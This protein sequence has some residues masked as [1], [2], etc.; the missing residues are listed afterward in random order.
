MSLIEKEQHAIETLQAFVPKE[1]Y[2]VAFS[3]GKDSVTIKK[4]CDL[5]KVKYDSHYNVTSIDPPELVQFIKKEYPDVLFEKPR[6]KDG[7][8]ITMM[9][10]IPKKKMPPTRLVR[11]CCE[12]LKEGGGAGR[13][14]ITGVR[15]AESLNR[16]NNQGLVTVYKVNKNMEIPKGSELSSKG[17]LILNNDND[18]TREF[19]ESCYKLKK[20]VINP[21]IDWSDEDV[22][23]F[24]HKYNVP[25]CSLYDQGYKRLGCIG[26]PMQGAK[27]QIS[28]FHHYPKYFNMYMRAFEKMIK[29]RNKA[30]LETKWET[31]EQVMEWWV[32]V[33]PNDFDEFLNMKLKGGI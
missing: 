32:G 23:E 28:E 30:N 20:T 21:I 17:G 10:L 7:T 4:L 14:V 2:Y 12:K 1:G 29:E 11:Y 27:K 5:A 16:R 25:Y 13:M 18:D 19:L 3:G 24:I 26:C 31:P 33:N 9:N 6:Y 15:W 8:Q 22:W